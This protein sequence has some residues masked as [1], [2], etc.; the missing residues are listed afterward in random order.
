L[1]AQV[2]WLLIGFVLLRLV[3]RAGV[4]NYSAVGA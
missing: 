2:A 1:G 3:W 4:K